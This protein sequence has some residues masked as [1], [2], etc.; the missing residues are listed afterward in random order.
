MSVIVRLPMTAYPVP[1]ACRPSPDSC[2]ES[3]YARGFI[4]AGVPMSH[5]SFFFLEPMSDEHPVQSPREKRRHQ[6]ISIQRTSH[7]FSFARSRAFALTLSLHRLVCFI[8]RATRLQYTVKAALASQGATPPPCESYP[9][10]KAAPSSSPT[11]DKLGFKTGVQS[12][13]FRCTR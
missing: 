1:V 13:G 2:A 4:T 6:S 12:N 5:F 10:V 11:I 8:I 3:L 9:H 7:S